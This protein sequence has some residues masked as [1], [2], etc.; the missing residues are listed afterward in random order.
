MPSMKPEEESSELPSS[1]SV[2]GRGFTKG[3]LV[4]DDPRRANFQEEGEK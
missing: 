4:V 3:A 1:T 2:D